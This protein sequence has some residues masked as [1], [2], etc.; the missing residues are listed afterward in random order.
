MILYVHF[1]LQPEISQRLRAPR[2]ET[3]TAP[4]LQTQKS[5]GKPKT[6]LASNNML[7]IHS[8]IVNKGSVECHSINSTLAAV[9][10][11]L[12]E[13]FVSVIRIKQLIN[14]KCQACTDVII[15]V[16]IN[17]H[18]RDLR[19]LNPE[20][21]ENWDSYINITSTIFLDYQNSNSAKFTH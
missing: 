1:P 3:E 9:H 13:C 20:Y 2:Y 18:S 8:K 10:K 15:N 5:S 19:D 4:Q 16:S 6:I 11:N 21:L 17:E 7:T 14:I 12:N